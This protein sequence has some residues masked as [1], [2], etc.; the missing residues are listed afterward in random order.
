MNDKKFYYLSN[1]VVV[2]KENLLMKQI[3]ENRGRQ[4]RKGREGGCVRKRIVDVRKRMDERGFRD[5]S[6]T[7]TLASLSE[8]LGLIPH[9]HIEVHNHF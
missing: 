7:R 8:D 3:V 4:R 9:T 1:T 2:V 6:V 5:G